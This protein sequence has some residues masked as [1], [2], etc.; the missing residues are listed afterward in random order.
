MPRGRLLVLI[1]YYKPMHAP[2]AT[3]RVTIDRELV[4][5]VQVPRLR[6][7]NETLFMGIAK[8]VCAPKNLL[9]ALAGLLPGSLYRTQ[10]RSKLGRR[11]RE[12]SDT[13]TIVFC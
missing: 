8:K 1:G 9:R 5:R 7:G 11:G 10:L 12:H 13:W 3:V 4:P 6:C 2:Q